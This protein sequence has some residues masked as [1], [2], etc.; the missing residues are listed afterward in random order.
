MH[1]LSIVMSL[2]FYIGSENRKP[3]IAM[4]MMMI[5]MTLMI[6]LSCLILASKSYKSF[7]E[8]SLS[9]LGP[10]SLETQQFFIMSKKV[11][12]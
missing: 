11:K 10:A 9:C 4:M 12:F 3:A 2:I 1:V 5:M 6:S 7:A 8:I